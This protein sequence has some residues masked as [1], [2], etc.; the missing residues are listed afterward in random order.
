M[1]KTGPRRGRTGTS[2]ADVRPVAAERGVV[3][4]RSRPCSSTNSLAISGSSVVEL[5]AASRE[6]SLSIV[7]PA[8]V[9]FAPAGVEVVEV[10]FLRLEVFGGD[11]QRVAL[12]AGVDVL[13]DEDDALALLRAGRRR[14]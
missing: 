14:S 9:S 4:G 13:G 6:N 8:T 11:A 2:A 10:D 5:A 3:P 1:P 7:A 12:D